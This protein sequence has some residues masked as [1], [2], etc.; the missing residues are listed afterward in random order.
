MT[1]FGIYL[2]IYGILNVLVAVIIAGRGKEYTVT[3]GGMVFGAVWMT[4]NLMGILL[5]GTGF[6]I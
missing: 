5:W 4:F 2:V 6:G 1:A 3:P